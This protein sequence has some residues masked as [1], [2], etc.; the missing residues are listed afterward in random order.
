MDKG[1]EIV[2]LCGGYGER[3]GELT[4]HKQKCMLPYKNMPILEYGLRAASEAFGIFQPILCVGYR[5]EDVKNYFGN[6][7][8]GNVIRYVK[9]TAGTEDKGA[10]LSIQSL[11]SGNAFFVVHGDIIYDK[12]VFTNMLEV[13][14]STPSI[15]TIAL[16]E[17]LNES[18]HDI[19][20]L[21]DAR[22]QVTEIRIPQLDSRALMQLSKANLVIDM[23]PHDMDIAQKKGEGYLRDMGVVVYDPTI[24]TFITQKINTCAQHMIWLYA[25]AVK[26]GELVTGVRYTDDW[27]HFQSPEDLKR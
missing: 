1:P 15:A 18:M 10:L 9:H 19:A 21:D 4:T 7:W 11:L 20:L 8:Q 6:E 16:A 12:S 3:M 2:F 23:Y 26:R 27:L 25:A 24:F 14:T 17:K 13:H 5:S 22:H